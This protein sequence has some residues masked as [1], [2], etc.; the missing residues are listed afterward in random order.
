MTNVIYRLNC[1]DCD[2]SYIGQTKRHLRIRVNEHKNDVKK[3][4]SMH[5]VVSTH[6]LNNNHEFDFSSPMVLHNEKYYK[7]RD[8]SEM[9]FIKKYKNNINLQKDTE[10]LPDVYN[11]IIDLT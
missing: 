3:H 4:E 1:N 10:R 11:G 6:R 8:I 9:F 5:S 2:K 7:K